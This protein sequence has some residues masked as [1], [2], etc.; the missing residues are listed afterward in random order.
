MTIERHAD[1]REACQQ[2]NPMRPDYAYHPVEDGFDWA[3][4]ATH[5]FQP[6]YLVVFRSVRRPDADYALLKE[7]DD[8]AYAAA[9]RI[10]GLLRYF[11]GELGDDRACLSFCL[12]ESR[13]LAVKAAD[14]VEHRA[15]AEIVTQAYE[16]YRL[17]RYR[18]AN[19]GGELA[20]YPVVG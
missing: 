11:R 18:V 19:T 7:H 3:S 8:R 9:R 10:G 6:L 13:E 14:A 17:E 20:F 1:F 12:W 5:D 4:L 2:L 16:S 15:A